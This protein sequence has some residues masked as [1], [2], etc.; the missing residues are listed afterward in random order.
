METEQVY[1]VEEAAKLMKCH[2]ATITRAI[3]A[4]KLKAAKFGRDYRISRAELERFWSTSGGG[5]LFTEASTE[6]T[7][8]KKERKDEESD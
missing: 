7:T 4:G 1:T 3:K 6:P 8:Y 2:Y 5:Q